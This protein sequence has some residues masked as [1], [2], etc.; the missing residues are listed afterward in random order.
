[1]NAKLSQI[2]KHFAI[3]IAVFIVFDFP[4]INLK[5]IFHCYFSDMKSFSQL[6]P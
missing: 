3:E 5:I 1:M 4:L 6:L 2:G